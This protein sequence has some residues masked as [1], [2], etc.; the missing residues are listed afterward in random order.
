MA[1]PETKVRKTFAHDEGRAASNGGAVPGC[2]QSARTSGRRGAS[3]SRVGTVVG[4]AVMNEGPGGTG[5]AVTEAD[6]KAS[7]DP[8]PSTNAIAGWHR[9]E[10]WREGRA[11]ESGLAAR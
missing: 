3:Q 7:A 6:E 5:P 1:T 2:I 11:M 8:A 4:E 10:R 9:R